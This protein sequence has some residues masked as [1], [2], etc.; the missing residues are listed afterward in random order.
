[1]GQW[2]DWQGRPACPDVCV[3]GQEVVG[4]HY[5][6]RIHIHMPDGSS[7]ELRLDDQAHAGLPVDPFTGTFH[8]VDGSRMRFE[9]NAG[10]SV[11]YVPNGSSYL[12]GGYNS[13]ND[14]T[15]THFIDRNGNTLAYDAGARQWTD[16]LGRNIVNPLPANPVA[17]TQTY[18]RAKLVGGGEAVYTLKWKYLADV[19]TPDPATGQPPPLRYPGDYHCSPNSYQNVAPSLFTSSSN[20]KV[21]VEDDQSGNPVL[22]N[23]VVLA[24]IVLPPA[25]GTSYRFTYTVYGEIDKIFFPA[26]ATDSFRYDQVPTLSSS[27]APYGQTN[28]GVIERRVSEQGD[29]TDNS[30]WTYSVVSTNPYTVRTTR[31]DLSYSERLLRRSR[32]SGV[33]EN[34]ARF[35]FDD[36]R[37]G[38]AYEE[39]EY[40]SSHVMLRRALHKWVE[41]GPTAGGYSTA[42]RDPFVTKQVSILLDG[43]SNALTATTVMRYE[44]ASQPLNVTSATQYSYDES[45]NKTTAE[46]ATIDSFNPPDSMAIRTTETSYVDDPAYF[47]RGLV[48]LPTSVVLRSGM[49][50]SGTQ[51]SRSEIHY[52]QSDPNHARLPCGATV[53]WSNPGTTVRGNVTTTSNWLNTTGGNLQ[54]HVQYDECGTLKELHFPVGRTWRRVIALAMP[55]MRQV[56]SFG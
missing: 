55:T 30:L 50:I 8:A 21:C 10:G 23:P 53:G 39:R 51:Q 46:T 15:A 28:R 36:A 18:Y 19:L 35:E 14:L 45:M 13:G 29:G 47:A 37:M 9:S 43:P 1:M 22:F 34:F 4:D 44:Q 5:V 54:S 2:F 7:H 3:P 6:K 41:T 20:T 49:P 40:N 24:E 12:F 42:A 31:P 11:L 56:I 32:Y 16:T 48:A 17:N 52:D 25:I 38:M 27:K 33:G 26:G